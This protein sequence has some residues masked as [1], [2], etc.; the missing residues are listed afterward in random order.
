VASAE[1]LAWW[2]QAIMTWCA[3]EGAVEVFFTGPEYLGVPRTLTDDVT[4]LYRALL[5][6]EPD[7]GGLVG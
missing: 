2:T 7:A 1:E 6:Q 4:A 3:V 5:A